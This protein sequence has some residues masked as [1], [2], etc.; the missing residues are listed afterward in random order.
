MRLEDF[1]LQALVCG[2]LPDRGGGERPVAQVAASVS[3]RLRRSSD[4]S[5]LQAGVRKQEEGS[6]F[7]HVFRAVRHV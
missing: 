7:R 4:D 2:V 3:F 6:D 5:A 1:R